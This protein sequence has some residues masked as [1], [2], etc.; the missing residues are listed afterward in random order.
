MR[1]SGREVGLGLIEVLVASALMVTV[2]AVVGSLYVVVARST[3]VS[4]QMGAGTDQMGVAL[5]NLDAQVRSGYWVVSDSKNCTDSDGSII[6]CPIVKVLTTYHAAPF[7][8]VCW[9]WRMSPL[10]GGGGANVDPLHQHGRLQSVR[11]APG[12]AGPFS[13]HVEA[14]GLDISASSLSATG[15]FRALIPATLTF[16]SGL[17]SGVRAQLSIA[18]D[19]TRRLN[20]RFDV[21]VRNKLSSGSSSILS[22]TCPWP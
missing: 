8:A 16:T 22:L 12:L 20:T 19:A 9:V 10:P 6:S 7:G 1:A 17:Y 3:K 5:A 18:Q 13:W 15:P 21:V 11:Y 4:D 2:L 14:E